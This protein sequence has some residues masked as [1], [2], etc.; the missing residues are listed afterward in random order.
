MQPSRPFSNQAFEGRCELPKADPYTIGKNEMPCSIVLKE[1]ASKNTHAYFR[2][3]FGSGM[4]TGEML[5][6]MWDDYD[7]QSFMVERSRTRGEIVT[8]K[9]AFKRA[10]F[11]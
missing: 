9:T 2:L 6:L 4:R 5:A 3:A 7:G 8:T 1:N 11:F 10:G